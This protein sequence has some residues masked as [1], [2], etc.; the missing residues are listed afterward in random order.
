MEKAIDELSPTLKNRYK[1]QPL[2]MPMLPYVY[3]KNS[4]VV[5]IMPQST[6]STKEGKN[7][8]ANSV[9]ALLGN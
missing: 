7:N 3:D 6:V 2:R 1:M 4:Q 9:D 5:R 8:K